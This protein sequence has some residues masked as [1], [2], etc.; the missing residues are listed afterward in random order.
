MTWIGALLYPQLRSFPEDDRQR[1]LR[2]A[3]STPFD[4]IELLGIALGLVL[5]TALTRY[6][7]GELNALLRLTAIL[8]NFAVA[9]P[10]LVLCVG[11]FLVRRVRRGL[12]CE[13]AKRRGADRTPVK[14]SR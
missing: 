11:P 6:Q 13:L 2:A 5:V 4:V 7:A 10:L 14:D 3:K 12:E 9:V 8:L 1:A